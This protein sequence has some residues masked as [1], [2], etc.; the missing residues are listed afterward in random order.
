[1]GRSLFETQCL[2]INIL[3]SSIHK[4]V[5]ELCITLTTIR[6]TGH[7]GVKVLQTLHANRVCSLSACEYV[8]LSLAT[9][10]FSSGTPFFLPKVIAN[11]YMY[12]CILIFMHKVLS[13]TFMLLIKYYNTMCKGI[14]DHIAYFHAQAFH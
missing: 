2:D 4:N 14:H 5:F 11:Y 8:V 3:L 13:L 9:R 7:I 1:M 10:A 12:R 6:A